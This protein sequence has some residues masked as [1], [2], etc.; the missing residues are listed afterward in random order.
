MALACVQPTIISPAA[1]CR[2]ISRPPS[3]GRAGFPRRTNASAARSDKLP[4]RNP[5]Q[6]TKAVGCVRLKNIGPRFL[7]KGWMD[8]AREKISDSTPKTVTGEP[9]FAGRRRPAVV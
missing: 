5:C 4:F 7:R 6:G 1:C 3:Q 9:N 2:S 8:E